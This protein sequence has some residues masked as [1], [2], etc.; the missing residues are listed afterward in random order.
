MFLLFTFSKCGGFIFLASYYT[1][2][3]F[4]FNPH[5]SICSNSHF[6]IAG[7]AVG[8]SR[9]GFIIALPEYPLFWGRD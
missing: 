2:E 5:P 8:P 3:M 9:A 6:G 7:A 1:M 4:F